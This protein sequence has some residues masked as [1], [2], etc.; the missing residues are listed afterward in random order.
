MGGLGPPLTVHVRPGQV[1][2]SL[3]E[4]DD[5]QRYLEH[6]HPLAPVQWGH[7]EDELGWGHLS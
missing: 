2:E 1:L 5:R 3:I 6:R 7:L 4:Q